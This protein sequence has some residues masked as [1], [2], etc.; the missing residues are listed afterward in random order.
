MEDNIM[1]KKMRIA[2]LLTTGL[3][4]LTPC[5]AASMGLTAFAEDTYAIN[6]M[7]PEDKDAIEGY[8]YNAYQI[9]S[10][11]LYQKNEGSTQILVLSD[12]DW[13]QGFNST[14]FLAALKADTAFGAGDANLFK[15]CTNATEVADVL[16]SD[17]MNDTDKLAEFAKQAKKFVP[18]DGETPQPAGTTSTR[19]KVNEGDPYTY[20]INVSNPGYYLIEETAAP[21]ANED[22]P[23][24][25]AYSRF[26]LDVVGK[27][28]VTTKRDYPT[29]EKKIVEATSE[30]DANAVNIGDTVSYKLTSKVPN[31]TGYD[32]YFFNVND[33]LSKGLTYDADSLVVKIGTGATAVPATKDTD[34][35]NTNNAAGGIYYYVTPG[36]DANGNTTLKIV[37]E[38]FYNSF[39]NI[40]PGTPITITYD[41]VLNN[42]A[43]IGEAGN[44][45]TASLI[46]S[47]NPNE[48]GD[49]TPGK[50]D[51]PK[52]D[53]VTGETPKDTVKTFTTEII[54]DKIDATT[55][56]KLN[57]VK[58]RLTGTALKSVL[59]EEGLFV[60]N[61]TVTGDDAYYL[62]KDGS[63]TK[64]A[65][66]AETADKY[67]STTVTY[68]KTT[69]TSVIEQAA[70]V[71]TEGVTA[72]VEGVNGVLKFT[73]LAAGTYTITEIETVNG[74]NLLT[75]PI[76]VTIAADIN[77]EAQTCEFT[78]TPA[79][80]M[81]GN[82][83]TIENKQ[84]STLPSTG[85]IGTK[86]FF[87][88]GAVM[89]IGSGI[90][91][92]T[93]KRMAGVEE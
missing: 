17:A 61:S 38:D 56:A 36:T 5:A 72:E 53:S 18:K 63:F 33:T 1:K 9:F 86:L 57:G 40:A 82:K 26:M 89:A 41:A 19:V 49:G 20:M 15:D 51:E 60:K 44:P 81:T 7:E 58:F 6:I 8:T 77:T 84:G 31:L 88:F 14:G 92:V 65:A 24:P 79:D 74:Y 47:N 48:E 25:V 59:T 80:K 4:A 76:T 3:L 34:T 64:D 37:F 90:Y 23:D 45:N 55:K 16:K 91:L 42:D 46:Y 50:P 83:I 69:D 75:S 2:A 11:K 85:G 27:A 66:T 30:V 35:N 29:L 87:V 13:G 43:V 73:G 67:A 32:K 78:Y 70:Y 22:D 12:I 71:D 10:G 54:I 68:A 52:D 21:K 62:L 93:K 39:K 28:D